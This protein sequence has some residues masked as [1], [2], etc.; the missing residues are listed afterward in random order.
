MFQ[1]IAAYH[2]ILKDAPRTII[3][4]VQTPRHALFCYHCENTN[5]GCHQQLT[6]MYSWPSAFSGSQNP[7]KLNFCANSGD[8]HSTTKAR[9]PTKGIGDWGEALHDVL[10]GTHPPSLQS[11]IAHFASILPPLLSSSIIHHHAVSQV[12]LL[13][14]TLCP[15]WGSRF[16]S[17]S[18]HRLP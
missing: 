9:P 8:M 6:R 14:P 5:L 16:R 17:S 2:E 10:R 3:D 15:R 13:I 18:R 7:V 11:S 12:Q 1:D 4:E